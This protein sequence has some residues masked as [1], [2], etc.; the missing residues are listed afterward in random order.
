MKREYARTLV[1]EWEREHPNATQK[2]CC[3]ALGLSRQTVSMFSTKKRIT[4]EKA[5]QLVCDWFDKNPHSMVKQC[6]EELNISSKTVGKYYALW[7][8]KQQLK[9][10]SYEPST[11]Q[12]AMFTNSNS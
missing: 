7:K 3:E 10:G 9:K 12:I 5:E 11:E 6:T 2:E 1:P 8:L 4:P